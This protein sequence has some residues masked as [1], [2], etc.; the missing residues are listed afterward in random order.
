[1]HFEINDQKTKSFLQ[2]HLYYQILHFIMNH[3]FL[4]SI[5]VF[6]IFIYDL[7]RQQVFIFKLFVQKNLY[8]LLFYFQFIVMNKNLQ[9]TLIVLDH[10]YQ[11]YV[12]FNYVY[13]YQVLFINQYFQLVMFLMVLRSI[14]NYDNL[15]EHLISLK[16]Y[17][18]YSDVNYIVISFNFINFIISNLQKIF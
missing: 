15:H 1:M 9:I 7:I 5:Y 4:K 8:F 2:F 3:Y 18:Q 16:S 6:L 17:R 10:L 11:Y 12:M 13:M 14:L